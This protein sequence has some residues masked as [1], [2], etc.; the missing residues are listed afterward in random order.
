MG[1]YKMSD[2]TDSS[3]AIPSI[4]FIVPYRDREQ[5]QK[6]FANH[7]KTVMEDFSEDLYKIW[8]IH[9][10][11]TRAVN[12]GALKNSGFLVAKERYPNDY[13][14][15][16]FVFN[17]VDTMPYT[18][19]F[20][21]YETI[22]GKVKHFYG[23]TYA[24]GGIVSIKGSD[25]ERIN[26]FPNFWAWGYEDNTLQHR[27]NAAPNLE[28]DR[29]QYYPL[30]DKNILQLHDGVTRNIN[31][32][33]FE[34]FVRKTNEGWKNINQLSYKMDETTGFVNVEHFSTGTQENAG[35]TFTYDLR[36]GNSP[37]KVAFPQGK[38]RGATM[39]MSM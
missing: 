32:T 9:Q 27:V 10:C 7:M 23:F 15:I 36:N 38:R 37:F 21:N 25:F 30:L 6:F 34:K 18:K 12:R 8:Y 3:C 2:V 1:I 16:T 28:V 19:N 14:N 22:Q 11:D 33:E 5:Q 4:I 17:D 29:D 35:E 31:R 26:G 20:L 13:R 24:L 39:G